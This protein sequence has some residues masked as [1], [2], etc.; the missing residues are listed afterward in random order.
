MDAKI[1]ERQDGKLYD[2]KTTKEIG[3]FPIRMTADANQNPI[4]N[5]FPNEMY[6]FQWHGD[7]FDIPRNAI[8]IA[9]SEACKNQAFVFNE[10]VIALQFHFEVNENDID[11]MVTNFSH[12]LKKSDYIQT[13]DEI[14]R[15]KNYILANTEF[16]NKILDK[17]NM[18]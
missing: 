11:E 16:M 7:T 4:F 9:V 13:T 5:M 2:D 14:A 1:G 15:G 17:L 6:V 18:F 8:H 10:K 12:E 3:W